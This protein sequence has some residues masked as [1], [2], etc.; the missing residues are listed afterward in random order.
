M[1]SMKECIAL[2]QEAYTDLGRRNAQVIARRRNRKAFA[3]K[4][5]ELLD[6]DATA[7]GKAEE[8][9]RRSDVAI[10]ST[11]SADPILFGEWLSPGCHV[12]GMIGTNKFDARREL[13][14]ECARRADLIIANLIEQITL[15]EQPEILMPMRKGYCSWNNIYHHNNVGMGIQ[16]AS[17]C[18]RAIEIA[19]KKGIGT[20][21]PLW[22]SS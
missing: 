16:F 2:L 19:R 12:I 13:D 20:E 6:I 15:D 10:A 3:D 1:V 8:A 14:G 11:N 21:L 5:G 22:T 17:V 4:M 7:V 9:I 18:K